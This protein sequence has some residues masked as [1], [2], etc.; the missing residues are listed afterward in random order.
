MVNSKMYRKSS[1]HINLVK[2]VF[3][4]RAFEIGALTLAP[5]TNKIAEHSKDAAVDEYVCT[6][7]DEAG[8]RA[9]HDY[10]EAARSA[11]HFTTLEV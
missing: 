11:I 1:I 4:K 5:A 6:L 10:V 8:G 9:S 2:K 7:L 3:A